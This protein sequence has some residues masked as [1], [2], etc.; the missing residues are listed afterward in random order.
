[1]GLDT[2]ELV[3]EIE[4]AF[5]ITIPD[6]DA[7]KIQT[8]G[9]LY[10]Y[11]MLRLNFERQAAD[12]NDPTTFQCLSA[13]AFYRFRRRLIS[14]L[15]IPRRDIRV[16]TQLDTLIPPA[17]RKAE[18]RQLEQS[19]GWKLPRLIHP[20]WVG[21]TTLSLMFILPTIGFLTSHLLNNREPVS[22]VICGIAGS[23]LA[24]ILYKLTEPI[25][26]HFPVQTIRQIVPH[27]VAANRIHIS[28][29]GAGWT[30]REVWETMIAIIVAQLGVDA[31][32]L[33]DT[34]HFV[35]DSGAD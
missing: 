19:L 1:M 17:N 25:A 5:N 16:D 6:A 14:N 29:P 22:F 8:V 35:K 33:T 13:L 18:W 10:R 2:V 32:L 31:N 27:L 23:L 20:N 3:M 15:K 30:R 34:T 21:T 24:V 4:E 28:D 9:D 26:I 7:E 12:V 11:L